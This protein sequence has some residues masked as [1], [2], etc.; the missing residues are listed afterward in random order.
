MAGFYVLRGAPD[1]ALTQF[2]IET[3]GTVLFVLVMR[4]LPLLPE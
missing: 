1:L 3:L 2:A 4:A